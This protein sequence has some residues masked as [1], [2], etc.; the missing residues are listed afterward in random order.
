VFSGAVPLDRGRRPRRPLV[1]AEESGPGSGADEGVRPTVEN[2]SSTGALTRVIGIYGVQRCIG[3]LLACWLPLA[4]QSDPAALRITVVEGEGVVYAPGGRAT[5]GMTVEVADGSGNPLPG[6][7]VTFRL[8]SSGASGEFPGGSR[9]ESVAA[10]ADGRASV[11]GVQWNRTPGAIEIAI[12]AVQGQARAATVAH[13]TLSNAVAQP[14]LSSSSG[15]GHKFLWI[16]LLAAG[17]AAGGIATAGLA[18][19][20]GSSTSAA[21]AAVNAPHIGPPAVTL[22]HP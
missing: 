19:K 7:T 15:G 13:V 10:G 1:E 5:R 4:A 2:I 18:G 11:W 6:A 17:G 21:A 22:G 8:P 14:R 3:V 20:S 9:S 12:A 16:V